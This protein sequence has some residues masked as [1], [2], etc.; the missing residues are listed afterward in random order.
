VP[1]NLLRSCS[2]G[3]ICLSH[4]CAFGP[5]SDFEV[6]KS[7]RCYRLQ[8]LG[9]NQEKE[10]PK[11]ILGGLEGIEQERNLGSRMAELCQV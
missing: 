11:H 8:H 3:S 5:L 7:S 10:Q 1:N 2:T 9:P 4:D 6:V